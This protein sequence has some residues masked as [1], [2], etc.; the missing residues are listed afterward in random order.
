MMEYR[1]NGYHGWTAVPFFHYS[2]IPL[3]P[4]MA[5]FIKRMAA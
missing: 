1:N 4:T 5:G 3:F 2:I